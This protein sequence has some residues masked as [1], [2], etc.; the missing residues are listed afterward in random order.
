MA[1]GVFYTLLLADNNFLT[2][3][4]P[5]RLHT[6]E[7][8][9]ESW[10]EVVSG[11]RRRKSCFMERFRLHAAVVTTFESELSDNSVSD[12]VRKQLIRV[13]ARCCTGERDREWESKRYPMLS[14]WHW[15][16]DGTARLRTKVAFKIWSG[17]ERR[18]PSSAYKGAEISLSWWSPKISSSHRTERW[19]AFRAQNHFPCK[20]TERREIPLSFSL[21]EI[22]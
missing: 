4:L 14:I 3:F 21:A 2:H 5:F 1:V 12:I 20:K 15:K 22:A 16:D 19:R 8:I 18:K 6:R 10:G 7:E 13:V 17:S 11:H 9:M